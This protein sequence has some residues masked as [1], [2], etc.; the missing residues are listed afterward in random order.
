MLD[1]ATHTDRRIFHIHMRGRIDSVTAADFEYYYEDMLRMGQRFFIF[2]CAQLE[3][4]SSA[5]IASLVKLSRRLDE[6]GGRAMVVH[7]NEEIAMLFE[8]FGLDHSIA[9][10]S[11][12]DSARNRME[13][14]IAGP[15][16]FQMNEESAFPLSDA[17]KASP[18]TSRDASGSKVG[19]STESSTP[20]QSPS[21]ASEKPAEPSE[22]N[23]N[24]SA[25]VRD[26]ESIFREAEVIRCQQCGVNLRIK[27]T[28]P[29]MCP[30][31][32]IEFFVKSDGT[33]S[34]YEKF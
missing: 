5:G 32:G 16:T 6:L 20:R 27:K 13:K 34:F 2:D 8:F 30:A 33:L 23:E 31:C 17:Q 25:I 14:L 19:L 29:H 15:S 24:A 11:S 9:I 26:R 18:A 21:V 22:K 4:L 28:G 10:E 7:L 1:M 12:I 3:F